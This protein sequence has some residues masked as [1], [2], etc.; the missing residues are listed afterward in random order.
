MHLKPWTNPN[1]SLQTLGCL[2]ARGSGIPI[3]AYKRQTQTEISTEDSTSFQKAIPIV[4]ISNKQ[5]AKNKTQQ[6]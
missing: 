1:P 2:Q 3:P 5:Q 4:M 6:Q